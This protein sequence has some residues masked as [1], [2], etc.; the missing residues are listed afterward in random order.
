MFR[1]SA[2][3]AS[4]VV[5]CWRL[6]RRRRC[7]D[8][9]PRTRNAG[10]AGGAG[11]QPVVADAMEPLWQDMQ[12]EAPDEL[13]GRERHRAIPRPPVAVVILEAEGHAAL[14][15]TDQPAVRDGTRWV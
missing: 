5:L 8:Q 15:E 10:L 1:H 9:L 3:V 12:Q 13:V 7:G 11:E 14:V 2:G 6:D 4:I